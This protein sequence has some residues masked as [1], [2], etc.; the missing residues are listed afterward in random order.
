MRYVRTVQYNDVEGG[1]YVCSF[2]SRTT[3]A[4]VQRGG[5]NISD[6]LATWL[7]GK[8][9]LTQR[10]Y[11]QDGTYRYRVYPPFLPA[12]LRK[13]ALRATIAPNVFIFVGRNGNCRGYRNDEA[14]FAFCTRCGFI[15]HVSDVASHIATHRHN[16]TFCRDC[17]RVVRRRVERDACLC[18]SCRAKQNAVQHGY[19]DRPNKSAPI[20]SAPNNRATALHVGAEIEVDGSNGID[21]ERFCHE[22]NAKANKEPFAPRWEFERDS[23]IN[24]GVEVIS[25]PKTWRDWVANRDEVEAIY[26]AARNY[27]GAFNDYNGLHFHFDR[28]F[29]GDR[30]R[31]NGVKMKYYVNKFYNLFMFLSFRPFDTRTN[32]SYAARDI[33]CC[34][35]FKAVAHYP[36]HS[37]AFNNAAGD[38]TFELRTF[39][40]KIN[41]AARF[42]VALDIVY[43]LAKWSKST[44]FALTEKASEVTL[45]R[46]LHN[47][48]AVAEELTAWK[49]DSA[50][51]YNHTNTDTKRQIDAFLTACAA[52]SAKEAGL[53]VL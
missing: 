36:S 33:D 41:T 42:Y 50:S 15:M 7:A 20:F 45:V 30:V 13:D 28:V 3:A 1:L 44:P 40:G 6:A 52:R 31:E 34:D 49:A 53:C 17:G 14:F 35:L 48:K 39:G 4:D 19:H 21:A 29:F 12:R 32:Y 22:A 47:P 9:V 27:D 10:V 51:L 24:G 5:R 11:E 38:D 23:S 46:Y 8:Y 25:A 43:A 37:S 16:A 26:T 2:T 18:S